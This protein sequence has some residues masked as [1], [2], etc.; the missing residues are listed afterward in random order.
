MSKSCATI[1]G[2]DDS[3]LYAADKNGF[4]GE[5]P[6]GADAGQP[7]VCQWKVVSLARFTTSMPNLQSCCDGYLAQRVTVVTC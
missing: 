5:S 7:N 3:V 4:V 6:A 2:Y 1:F